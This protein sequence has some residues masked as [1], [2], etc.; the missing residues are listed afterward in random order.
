MNSNRLHDADTDPHNVDA[1]AILD[2]CC[3]QSAA[4]RFQLL[5]SGYSAR[6]T[7]QAFRAQRIELRISAEEGS[8][9]ILPQSICCVTFP[10]QNSIC[11]FLGCV[12]DVR[13]QSPAQCKV[14]ATIPKQLTMTNLRQ[15]FRVPVIQQ[16]GLV[17]NI[18]TSEGRTFV[19]QARDIADD[20]MEIEF[21][22]N[23]D[24]RLA[25]GKT[26]LIELRFRDEVALRTAEVRRLAD[27]RCGLLIRTPLDDEEHRQ[28]GRM[29]AIVVLLRQLWLKSRISR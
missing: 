3:Q 2:E 11:A 20:G 19:V 6:G 27:S 15:S 25:V 23:E 10:H 28:A 5:H 8:E 29:H 22:P 7:F 12:I 21:A 17:V 16:S 4:C 14:I 18:Q 1:T 13:R 24:H 9:P 26:V